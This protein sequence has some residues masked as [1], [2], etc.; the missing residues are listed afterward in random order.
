M[1]RTGIGIGCSAAPLG[2]SRS[3]ALMQQQLLAARAVPELATGA[4]AG[5]AVA[6][7]TTRTRATHALLDNSVREMMRRHLHSLSISHW[8]HNTSPNPSPSPPPVPQV[9][10]LIRSTRGGGRH[11]LQRRGCPSRSARRR[12][13]W[14]AGPRSP[15]APRF[16]I[17]VNRLWPADDKLSRRGTSRNC[18]TPYLHT[19]SAS[20][21]G[22]PPADQQ[23]PP[24]GFATKRRCT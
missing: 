8:S 11:L 9:P 21:R 6:P 16:P 19:H 13:P 12:R 10:A 2:W 17:P 7:A 24:A 18:N 14:R 3:L 4:P 1:L 5:I 23:A 15:A 20:S 22:S